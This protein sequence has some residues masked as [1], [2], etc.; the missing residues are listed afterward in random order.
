MA[1][2]SSQFGSGSLAPQCLERANIHPETGLATDYL[3][4]FNEV[5]MLLE[6]ISAMPECIEDVVEWHPRTYEEHFKASSFSAKDLAIEAYHTGPAH[7]RLAL[8][9]ATAEIDGE[10]IS[11]QKLL[12]DESIPQE[13]RL[14]EASERTASVLHPMIMK[15]SGIIHG[16]LPEGVR[17]A[18]E[19]AQ[20]A[21]D[22]LFD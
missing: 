3:N 14:L 16:K 22:A 5:V 21:V 11:L 4:H 17:P 18:Y 2:T 10:V 13:A 6:M 20:A 15:A 9:Q 8:E 19:E 12:V 7:L 1:Q